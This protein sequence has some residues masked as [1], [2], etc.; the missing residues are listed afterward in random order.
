MMAIGVV[1]KHPRCST[2]VV[3]EDQT[4]DFT[5]NGRA[6]VRILRELVGPVR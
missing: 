3:T 2:S 6:V 1:V 5:S 4:V